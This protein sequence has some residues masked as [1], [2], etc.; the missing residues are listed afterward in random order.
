[1]LVIMKMLMMLM[2]MIRNDDDDD[3]DND[4]DDDDDD[5]DDNN[6]DDNDDVEDD[7]EVLLGPYKK[8]LLYTFE[9][10]L[11]FDFLF[12]SLFIRKKKK[13]STFASDFKLTRK[14]QNQVKRKAR[15]SI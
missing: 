14:Q 10:K 12:L 15:M 7:D 4:D 9:L 8:V 6:D 5:G 2:M 1:M 3:D 13:S 11:Y